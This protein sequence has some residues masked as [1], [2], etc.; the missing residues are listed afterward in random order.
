MVETT[1]T[2][3]FATLGVV[4]IILIIVGNREMMASDYRVPIISSRAKHAIGIF[5][6]I[7]GV[8]VFVSQFLIHK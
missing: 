3:V 6:I 4:G 1:Q 2:L 8:T 5:F 7:V